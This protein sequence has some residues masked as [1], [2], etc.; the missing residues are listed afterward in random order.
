MWLFNIYLEYLHVI[1]TSIKWTNSVPWLHKP[2]VTWSGATRGRTQIRS[3]SLPADSSAGQC[4]RP[5]LS[6][7]QP[8]PRNVKRKWLIYLPTLKLWKFLWRS[9]SLSLY[10]ILS[11]CSFPSWTDSGQR[12]WTDGEQWIGP[13]ASS[14]EPSLLSCSSQLLSVPPCCHT[15][16][17]H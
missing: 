7:R 9:F 6:S 1:F 15:G 3:V 5:S 14:L 8:L 12:F 13:L 11:E 16:R 2:H 17:R 10:F 4:F